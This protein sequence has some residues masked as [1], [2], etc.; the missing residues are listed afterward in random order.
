MVKEPLNHS[1]SNS[2]ELISGST[3]A[4]ARKAAVETGMP[5]W[6]SGCKCD[7]RTRVL[8]FDSREVEL[9]LNQKYLLEGL[10]LT[11]FP[12][13]E[14]LNSAEIMENVCLS[15]TRKW[16]LCAYWSS[17]V[18][19]SEA[20]QLFAPPLHK[21]RRG[22]STAAYRPSTTKNSDLPHEPTSNANQRHCLRPMNK[23]RHTCGGHHRYADVARSS[24]SF[25]KIELTNENQTTNLTDV[26][27]ALTNISGNKK[28][29]EDE[30]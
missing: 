23:T 27:V 9:T 10:I 22:Y 25:L 7:S 12:K 28:K 29:K 2:C 11:N 26:P 13:K 19:T 20:S 14:V 21:L 3:R 8:G 5:P 4:P 18:E 1:S 24:F 17:N 16:E 6:S 30:L 15:E